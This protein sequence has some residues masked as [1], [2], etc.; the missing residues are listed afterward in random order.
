MAPSSDVTVM[1]TFD[2]DAWSGWVGPLQARSPS[3][4]SRGEFSAVGVARL[5]RLLDRHGIPATFFVPGHTARHL[6]R[7]VMS[8]AERGDE[9]GHHG[10][11]HDN[12]AGQSADEEERN[13]VRG[14]EELERLLGQRPVGYRSPGWDLSIDSVELLVRHGFLYDSSMM[15]NDY[16]PYWCRSGTRWDAAGAL[17]PGRPEPLVELPVAWHRD[18][19]PLFEYQFTTQLLIQGGAAPSAVE[20]IWRGDLDYLID[21]HGSGIIVYTMHPEVIGHGHRLL[22]LDRLIRHCV[23]RGARFAR[24][25]DVA[26]DWRS[27]RTPSLPDYL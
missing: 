3:A 22:M 20:E 7:V 6:P 1:L 4:L 15:A 13:L 14:S 18:D 27:G 21:H 16:E 19:V 2:V 25:C 11:S 26:A 12:P 17:D 23:E 24:C 8:I 9:I 10:W 5:I